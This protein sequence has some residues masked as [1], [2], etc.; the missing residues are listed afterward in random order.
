MLSF[1]RVPILKRDSIDENHNLSQLSPF[2]VR[3]YFSIL[4][5]QLNVD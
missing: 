5:L 2:D 4:A 1:N 3:N